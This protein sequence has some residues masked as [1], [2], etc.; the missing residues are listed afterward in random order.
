MRMIKQ[1]PEFLDTVGYDDCY[2]LLQRCG[3][4]NQLQG[5]RFGQWGK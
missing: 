4:T 3:S 1:L 5:Y 2:G